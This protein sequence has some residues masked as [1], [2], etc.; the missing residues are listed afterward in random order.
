MNGTFGANG[1][2]NTTRGNL[3][4]N[5][6]FGANGI[7]NT[8]RGNFGDMAEREPWKSTDEESAPPAKRRKRSKYLVVNGIDRSGLLSHI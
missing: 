1:I 2:M 5:G 7:M 4:M 3:P 6:T 8:T